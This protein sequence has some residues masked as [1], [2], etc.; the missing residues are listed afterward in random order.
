MPE[1]L[2]VAKTKDAQTVKDTETASSKEE[3]IARL[4]VRGLFIVSVREKRVKVR[5]KALFSVARGK[6]GS[7][8]LNDLQ[9]LARNLSTTLS[10]GVTLLRSLEVIATQTESG[11]LEKVLRRC[12]EDV[13]S[14]LFLSEAVAKHPEVFSPLWQGIIEV[15]ETSGNLPLVLER[16]GEF[17]DV[18]IEFERK[19]KTAMVYP[20]I[21]LGA[22]V[23][24]I[25]GFFKFILPKFTAIFQQFDI[26]L[27]LATKIVFGI[28]QVFEKRFT[29][30]IGIVLALA[31]FV[32]YCKKSPEAR[33]I[34][35]DLV[36]KMP[37]IG[38]LTFY[39][40]LEQFTSTVYILLESGLSIVYTLEVATKGVGNPELEKHI[41]LIKE[42]VRGG[43][44]LS[45]EFREAGIFPV[46]ISEMTKIG[47]ETGTMP[48]VFKKIAAHYQRELATNI[49]RIVAAFEP[50]MIVFMGV[51][52]GGIVI[53]LFLPIFQ[54]A[55]LGQ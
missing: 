45:D 48:E 36:T 50:I 40:S 13:R 28:S 7:L 35:S 37:L 54:I 24:A 30:I 19:V 46:L 16:L 39:F 51:V 8:T 33:K 18:R 10:S 32:Y 5:G 34:W 22:A 1:Y 3:L 55:T 53:A 21:L 42:N 20:C 38:K 23:L 9:L 43:A 17:L 31:W 6:R 2:Y 52:V 47:E 41:F 44:S 26:E 4:R 15:G 11:K 12:I 25:G 27:P 14:G 49:E 29:I